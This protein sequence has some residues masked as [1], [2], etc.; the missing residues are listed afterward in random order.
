M[1]QMPLPDMVGKIAEQ[2]GLSHEEV[3]SRI[4]EKLDKLSGLISKEGAAHIIANELGVKLVQTEGIALIKN[5]VPGMRGIIVQGKVVRKYE[6]REFNTGER[7]GKVASLMMA[8]ES[9][10]VRLVL[11]NDQADIFDKLKEDD[12]LRITSPMVK[13]NMGRK[14]VHMNSLAK[15]DVNPKGVTIAAQ[16]GFLGGERPERQPAVRK[17]L[18]ELSEK[19]DNAEVFGTIVQVFDPRFFEVCPQCGKRARKADE[20]FAC[21]THGTVTPD[22]SYVM[23]LFLDDG[24]SNMRVV[25]WRSAV[26]RLT[27]LSDAEVKGYRGRLG[28]FESVKNDLLG[29]MVKFIGRVNRN[30]G[31][32][33]L[34]FVAN[35]VFPKP[36]PKEEL[37]AL[38]KEGVS[39]A[40]PGKTPEK[41][42]DHKDLSA[43]VE[44]PE[45][46]GGD[47]L[48][49]IDDIEDLE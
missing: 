49:D 24:S 19:D 20:G 23:N 3:N 35:L 43:A 45:D 46:V 38:E 42:V 14:E 12:V 21:E 29:N 22:Y 33:S 47:D 2:S 17:K 32:D 13:E 28:D 44:M 5:L 36:D 48:M 18:S 7:K 8:D 41:K 31:F 30:E 39:K 25:L 10:Q 34:E 27:G 1:I 26:Q 6:V 15:M 4:K 9:G 40:A 11:W 37:A 16:A